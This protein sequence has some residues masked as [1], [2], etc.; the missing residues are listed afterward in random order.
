MRAIL[1]RFLLVAVIVLLPG[2][3]LGSV[4]PAAVAAAQETQESVTGHAEFVTAS[5]FRFHYSFSAIRHA[6]GSVSGE[7]ENHVENAAT[8][9][10]VLMAHVDIV[11]F[12]ITGNIARIGGIIER[13]VGGVNAVGVEGFITV[14]DNGE[15][16]EGVADLAS[17]PGVAPGSA[18]AHCATG[19]PRPLFPVEHGNI[20]VRPAGA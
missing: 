1:F 14:V 3:P 2:I 20:Q 11:C 6:D 16:A 5:G 18:F 8:G 13:Q 10:F 7:F 12:T 4:G 19:L 9:E 15:G 17:P